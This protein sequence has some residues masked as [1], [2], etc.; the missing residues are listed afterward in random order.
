MFC[1]LDRQSRQSIVMTIRR[2][3]FDRHVLDVVDAASLKPFQK[4]FISDKRLWRP[5]V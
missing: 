2:A 4:A 5:L 1:Q 3:V